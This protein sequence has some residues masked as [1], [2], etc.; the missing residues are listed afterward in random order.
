MRRQQIRIQ[1]ETLFTSPRQIFKCRLPPKMQLPGLGRRG[2]PLDQCGLLFSRR[3]RADHEISMGVVPIFSVS[4]RS[5][6]S[7]LAPLLGPLLLLPVLVLLAKQPDEVGEE[8]LHDLGI[9]VALLHR[10]EDVAICV[11]SSD[12]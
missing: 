1:R 12:H 11:K 4:S 9:A 5:S 8:Q 7:S 6:D 10:D 3:P 2:L